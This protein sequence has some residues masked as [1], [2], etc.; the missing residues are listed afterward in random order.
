MCQTPPPNLAPGC[1]RSPP[2]YFQK[3]PFYL[4]SVPSISSEVLGLA[5]TIMCC[6][7]SFVQIILNPTNFLRNLKEIMIQTQTTDV[8]F[9]I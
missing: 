9:E 3:K 4:G 7:A 8:E 2:I 5:L 6:A 1:N